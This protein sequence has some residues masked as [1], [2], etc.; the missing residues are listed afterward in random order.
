MHEHGLRLSGRKRI[1]GGHV[2]GDHLVRA[3]DDFR[4]LAALFVPSRHLLDQRDVVGAEI[5]KDVLDPEVGHLRE[6]SRK[7]SVHRLRQPRR[8][9]RAVAHAA[10]EQ[11]APV[12][13][14]A[15]VIQNPVQVRDRRIARQ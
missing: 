3:Q 14:Q 12:R 9:Q 8:L 15:E 7:A 6:N 1:T 2:D 13:R 10:A 5:G 11:Q 4:M